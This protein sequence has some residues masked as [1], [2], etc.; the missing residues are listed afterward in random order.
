MPLYGRVLLFVCLNLIV[1]VLLIGWILKDYYGLGKD[2]LIANTVERRMEGMGSFVDSRIGW[3][4]NVSVG[5]DFGGNGRNPWCGF[6]DL[7]A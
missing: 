5:Q 3:S 7:S 2:D 1:G 6:G 4:G